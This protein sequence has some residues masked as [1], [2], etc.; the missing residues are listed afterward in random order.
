MTGHVQRRGKR[1]WRIKFDIGRDPATGKRQT[2][3]HTFRGTKKQAEAEAEAVRLIAAANSGQY[4]EP[5]KVTIAEFVDRWLRIARRRTSPTRLS[6]GM[7]S[8]C[9]GRSAPGLASA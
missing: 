1:S 3:F 7:S 6:H 2:Q 4:I 5:S 9:D 8:C